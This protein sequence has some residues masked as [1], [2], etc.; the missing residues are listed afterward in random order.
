[1][2][3]LPGK[4]ASPAVRPL[5]AA[6]GLRQFYGFLGARPTSGAVLYDATRRSTAERPEL[7]FMNDMTEKA[8]AWIKYQKALTPDK[9]SFVYFAPGATHAPHHVP[10]EW[11][12]K[13]KGKFDAAG[14]GPR[15][16]AGAA[17]RDGVVPAAPNWRQAAGDQGLDSSRPTKS[18]SS[19]TRP[20]CSRLCRLHR[21]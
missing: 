1:M 5:A 19:L 18:A 8:R 7:H 9:P 6:P 17:D 14:Q 20:R 10:K 2:R 16:V 3:R 15:A 4:P 11:I 12:A 13:W 21:P